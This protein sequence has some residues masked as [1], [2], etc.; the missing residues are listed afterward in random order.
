MVPEPYFQKLS[1]LN[2]I[3]HLERPKMPSIG[4]YLDPI[5]RR[6]RE[7]PPQILSPATLNDGKIKACH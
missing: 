4:R 7:G 6:L 3:R 2:V 5:K 1:D